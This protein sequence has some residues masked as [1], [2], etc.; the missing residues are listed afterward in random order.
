ME[1]SLQKTVLVL[2]NFIKAI[3]EALITL[4]LLIVG[5]MQ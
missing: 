3:M 4:K 5:F 2:A 1:I